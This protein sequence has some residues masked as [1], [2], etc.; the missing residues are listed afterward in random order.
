[1]KCLKQSS[2]AQP[3]MFLLVSSTDHITP[4]TGA[5]P[6]V[7]ISKNGGS[8]SSPSGAVSEVGNGWYKVAGN[9]TDT[10]TLGPLIVH[11]TATGADPTDERYEVVA[12]DP[13]AGTNLGLSAIPTANPGATGGL[14]YS[15]NNSNVVTGVLNNVVAQLA[16]VS[17]I[18]ILIALANQRILK[19]TGSLSPNPSTDLFGQNYDTPEYN[20]RLVYYNLNSW[21][22]W[23]NGSSYVL[24]NAIG[25]NGS[26]YWTSLTLE[27]TWTPNGTATGSPVFTLVCGVDNPASTTNITTVGSVTSGVTVSTNNDKDGYG[28]SSDYDT[29]KTAS[30]QTSVDAIATDVNTIDTNVTTLGTALASLI[31]K[32]TGMTSLPRWLSLIMGQ[33]S[34]SSTLAEIQMTPAGTT[35]DNTTKSLEAASAAT[36]V[37]V[38]EWNG[39]PVGASPSV[40]YVS[41]EPQSRITCIRSTTLSETLTLNGTVTSRSKAW[42]TVKTKK[43][44]TDDQATIQIVEGTGLV[45][46]NGEAVSG[47]DQAQGS[48]TFVD[49][50]AVVYLTPTL[51][52]ALDL[53]KFLYDVKVRIGSD[54]YQRAVGE[55][56]VI[57]AVTESIS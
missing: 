11:A 12:Y 22:I 53:N 5:T 9:T 36:D 26:A 43:S 28:L 30:T 54:T 33:G 57:A 16:G 35:Y 27:G 31:G 4:V 14:L 19:Y 8:F 41:N 44:L 38:V 32:F 10:S 47:L 39:Q 20:G 3:L 50:D 46:L 6:T 17:G 7:T 24:S 25:S 40:I 51:S 52:E 21:F 18:G 13:Q 2:T 55:F 45:V 48:L 56:V 1:M 37:N 42:F 23:W 34:D 15:P 49:G 29:A